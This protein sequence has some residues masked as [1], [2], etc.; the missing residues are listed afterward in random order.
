[1]AAHDGASSHAGLCRA[2][3]RWFLLGWVML[4]GCGTTGSAVP[5]PGRWEGPW[6]VSPQGRFRTT[7]YYGPWQCR[8]D[9]MTSCQRECA[10]QGHRLMGCIWLADMRF[11]WEGSLVILPIPVKAGSRFP[12]SHCCCDYPIVAGT[13]SR[14][15]QWDNI[16]DTFRRQW[17]RRFG[18]WPTDADGNNWPGH[19]IHD[20]QHGGPPVNPSNILPVATDIHATFTDAYP[21]CYAGGGRWTFVG[22]DRPY[23]D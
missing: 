1:M 3:A 16:R 5:A 11:D 17:G 6:L 19:H 20:L 8:Q 2:F 10:S 9:V 22:P 13:S 18:N 12:L 7:I 23:A 15:Q 4:V 21:Q 14:R